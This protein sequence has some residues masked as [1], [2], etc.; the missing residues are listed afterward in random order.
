MHNVSVGQMLNKLWFYFSIHPLLIFLK[1]I[2]FITFVQQ[3]NRLGCHFTG[4]AQLF[5]GFSQRNYV[6]I[7][8]NLPNPAEGFND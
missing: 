5:A 2:V 6:L 1:K 8:F 7:I 4:L 3:R